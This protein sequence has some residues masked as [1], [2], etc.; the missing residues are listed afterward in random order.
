MTPPN[1]DPFATFKA[2]EKWVI[3]LLR[4]ERVE[5]KLKVLREGWSDSD[6]L[7]VLNHP[8]YEFRLAPTPTYRPFTWAE[9]VAMAKDLPVEVIFKTNQKRALVVGIKLRNSLLMSYDDV[10]CTWIISANEAFEHLTFP[11]GTP[12]GMVVEGGV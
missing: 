11:D 3:E 9:L 12:F 1:Q 4:G 6:I 5:A 7:N 2:N 10:N 8:A